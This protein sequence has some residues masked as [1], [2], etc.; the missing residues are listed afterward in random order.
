MYQTLVRHDIPTATHI[1]IDREGLE[2]GQDPEGFIE[3]D[4]FVEM[5]GQRICKVWTRPG[6]RLWYRVMHG[7]TIPP[8]CFPALCR[9]TI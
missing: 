2:P 8:Q 4:D 9:E 6:L 1:I 3:D 5:N 7:L